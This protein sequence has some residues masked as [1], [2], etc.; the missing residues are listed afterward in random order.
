MT[1]S[2]TVK[3]KRKTVKHSGQFKK[4]DDPRRNK[5]NKNATAQAFGIKFR[6]ALAEKL[7]PEK[8]ADILIEEVKKK[9]PWAIQEYLDRV[10]G[11]SAQPIEHS[12]V[13]TLIMSN[14]FL[15]DIDN[16]SKP[17]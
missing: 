16:G 13:T 3:S 2:K 17:K 4:G 9:R 12:G 7:A 6:N 5:G 8:I 10:M 1:N 15:P 11:K 14:K